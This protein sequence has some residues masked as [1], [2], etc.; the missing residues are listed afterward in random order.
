MKKLISLALCFA[1]TFGLL[2][3][4]A[5]SDVIG[6]VEGCKYD[7]Y[8]ENGREG[9]LFEKG[10]VM[11]SGTV[12]N[13]TAYLRFD[14]SQYA[15][16][17]FGGCILNITMRNI[18]PNNK[19]TVHA[20]DFDTK[21]ESGIVSTVVLTDTGKIS[22]GFNISDYAKAAASLGKKDIGLSIHS[23]AD[24]TTV[25]STQAE[26]KQD[27]PYLKFTVSKPFVKGQTEMALPELTASE[28]EVML[29]EAIPNGHPR[30]L[31]NKAQFDRV[32]DNA[33]GKDKL[34]TE[35]YAK[36]KAQ[37]TDYLSKKPQPIGDLSVSYISRGIEA[38]WTIVPL[39]AFVYLIEGDEAYARRAWQEAEY[40]INLEHWGTYQYLD[41]NQAAL[42]IAICYD[43]LYD[44]L[45]P[46]QK[47]TLV[48]NLRE[49]HLDTVLDYYT[50]Y[51]TK[52]FPSRYT[53]LRSDS[54]HGVLNSSSIIIQALSIAEFDPAYSAQ[55]IS[56][57]MH[58]MNVPLLQ[59]YPDS[60]W[61]EG[62]D[63]W[64]FVG[65]MAIR[66][67]MSMNA[68]FG[69]C[70][71]YEK[72]EV[73]MNCAYH[74]I[75]LS[76]SG[77]TFT[78]NDGHLGVTKNVVYDKFIYGVLGDN[79]ALRKY[80]LENDDLA[81][82]F[83]CLYYDPSTD[84][85]SF[86]DQELKRDMLFRNVDLAIMRSSWQGEQ[87]IFGGML[88]QDSMNKLHRHMNSGSLSLHA[89]GEMWITNCGADS[90]SL[91]GYSSTN[92]FDY[93]CKRAEA[94]SCIVINPSSDGGQANMAGDIIDEFESKDRGAFAISDLTNTYRPYGAESYKRGVMLGDDRTSFYVQ[95]ELNLKNES[96]VYSFINFY[97][98]DIQIFEDGKSAIIS[99]G[100]KKLLM[101]VYCDG[102]YEISVMKS[103]PLPTS[104]H[105]PGQS[106]FDDIQKIAFRFAKTDGYN[107]TI[108][109]TPYLSDEE[110][111][112]IA[113]V[114]YVPLSQW[115]IED[116]ELSSAPSLSSLTADGALVENFHPQTRFYEIITE[117]ETCDISAVA[118]DDCEVTIQD[119][120][121]VYTVLLQKDGI[122]LN[123]YIVKL[124]KP[125]KAPEPEAKD[126]TGLTEVNILSASATADDGNTPDGAIDKD[127]N[128]RWS[129]SGEHS[130]TF[131]L[132]GY[133]NVCTLAIAFYNGHKR[134]SYFDIQISTD[135]RTWKTVS[136]GNASCGFSDK[137]EYFDIKPT[138]A[139]YVRLL[140]HGNSVNEWNSI[141][142][143]SI[144]SK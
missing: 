111:G 51:Q 110:V 115:S 79:K 18:T 40:F 128:T 117:A 135:G 81:H 67:V 35:T 12:Y 45:T 37:A 1:M 50:N 69:S 122:T 112:T 91:P 62:Y 26:K 139:N 84:Y 133:S 11:L 42:V 130:I 27:R 141:S 101:Q 126:L 143:I 83:F 19:I 60:L 77:G 124:T 15:E 21:K 106:T 75:Y 36:I 103:V 59:L 13:R 131:S 121:G 80:S 52:T 9:S 89:L 132:D 57:A 118:Q 120:E 86:A 63:Y 104:P 136:E 24:T 85:A 30:L 93:Y 119:N 140:C 95:D 97:K 49:K 33:F 74:P 76:T 90:Y 61:P 105:M 14:I 43:W 48:K 17:G 96:E 64:G 82:P 16:S 102:E 108:K 68:T 38:S 116:G 138:A 70:L 32:R 7:T 129:A 107:M 55:I 25:F 28:L 53:F 34:M 142:E 72:S 6:T 31:A 3:S 123:S 99:K 23:T 47:E 2:P 65:P 109:F 134:N 100:N 113:P 41:I 10:G 4:F 58:Y 73:F 98:S 22:Q 39:C 46:T 5:S 78:F 54:N 88:V 71:G 8:T 127:P 56:H 94:S 66:A 29:K 87:Y 44:W 114:E 137:T 144:Y 92:W 125:Q 20:Y